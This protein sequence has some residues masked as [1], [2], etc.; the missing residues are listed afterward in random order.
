[1]TNTNIKGL[2]I[3]TNNQYREILT[4]Y[5]LTEELHSEFDY[6]EDIN[7]HSFIKYKGEYYALDT[8]Q[9][10]DTFENPQEWHGILNFTVFNGLLIALSDCGD[11]AK[12]AYYHN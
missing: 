3:K 9:R 10:I 8:F 5:E 11:M 1:M 12:I 7:E 4:G 2:T 6:M